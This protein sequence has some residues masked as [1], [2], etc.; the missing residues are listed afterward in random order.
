VPKKFRQRLVEAKTPVDRIN[1]A[2]SMITV[3]KNGGNQQLIDEG[4]AA[5]DAAEAEGYTI[6]EGTRKGD[7]RIVNA[8]EREGST[9]IISFEEGR[10]D[11]WEHRNNRESPKGWH[12]KRREVNPS[13]G[14][15][16]KL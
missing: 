6:Q 11:R 12:T 9:R 13:F 16:C 3:G 2:V 10:S 4:Q 8:L 5:L 14:C 7:T 1:A 15:E